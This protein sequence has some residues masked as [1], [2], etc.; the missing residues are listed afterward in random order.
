MIRSAAMCQ[1]EGYPEQRQQI[2]EVTA[3]IDGNN[4]YG[5]SE[6]ITKILRDKRSMSLTLSPITRVTYFYQ[7]PLYSVVRKMA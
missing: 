2:N 5:S 3:V 6:K 7:Y 1:Q 4:I